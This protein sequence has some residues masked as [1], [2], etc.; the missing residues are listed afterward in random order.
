MLPPPLN[1]FQR[2]EAAA[3]ALLGSRQTFQALPAILV[4]VYPDS[5]IISRSV[6]RSVL[7][8]VLCCPRTS[9]SA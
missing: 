7:C 3:A 2:P 5:K 9:P 1:P 4:G 6:T 8:A